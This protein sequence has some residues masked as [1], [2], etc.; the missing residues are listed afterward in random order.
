MTFWKRQNHRVKISGCSGWLQGL[1]EERM[2]WC[3]TG[4]F[5]CTETTLTG[6]TCPDSLSKPI[7]STTPRVNPNVNYGLK[8]IIIYR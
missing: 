2:N 7:E 4:D 3:S 6:D 5:H 8:L 1:G